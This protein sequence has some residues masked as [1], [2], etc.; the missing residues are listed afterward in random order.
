MNGGGAIEI[1]RMNAFTDRPFSGNPA[2]VVLDGDGLSD[3]LMQSLAPQLNSISETVYVCTPDE[4]SADIRLRFFTATTEVD[5]CG[6]ATIS[7]LF[8]LAASGRAG[9]L[10]RAGVIR[11]QTRA[12]VLELGLEYA[13]NRLDRASMLQPV[14]VHALPSA[15]QQAASIL[16]LDPSDIRDDLP[17][18]CASTGIWSCY[19][20]LRDLDALAACV[21]DNELIESLW[22][23]NQ[24]FAGIYPFVLTGRD[25]DCL[26]TRGR[27]FSPPKFGIRE[28]PVTGT[29]SGALGA[30]LIHHG[31]MA[32][33][34]QLEARQGVE[35]GSPGS[36]QV[37]QAAGGAIKIWGRAVAV[38]RG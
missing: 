37:C 29:A 13:D 6:H 15:P 32:A 17:V 35:M 23:E 31:A 21:V 22:P 8:A 3:E 36:V 30:Y 19:V 2:G 1:W 25:G 18:A 14:P 9:E 33:N 7:A 38:Y 34:E 27:F 26:R 11:A 10:A 16:G 20:P 4:P 24:D 28:D 12:G 5:L